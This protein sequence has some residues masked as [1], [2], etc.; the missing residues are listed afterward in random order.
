[1]SKSLQTNVNTKLLAYFGGKPLRSPDLPWPKWPIYSKNL[2][3]EFESILAS[4]SWSI[5]SLYNGNSLKYE[6]FAKEFATYCGTKYCVPTDHGSSAIIA[7]LNA[8]GIGKEDE[9]ILPGLTWVACPISILKTGARP[10]LVD[11]DPH[12]QCI[13]PN[14]FEN[15]ITPQTK[16][17]LA[18]HLYSSMADMDRIR[19]IAKKNNIFVIEDCAQAHGAEWSSKKAGSIGDIGVFSFQHGKPLASG[20]G[21]AVVTSDYNF[22][23]KIQQA[24]T[25]GRI[26]DPNPTIGRVRLKEIGETIGGN[27]A[28]P[29]FQSAILLDSLQKLDSMNKTRAQNAKYLDLHLSDIPGL[30]PIQPYVK[31]NFRSYYHYNIRF[32]RTVYPNL[33]ATLFCNILESELHTWVHTTYPPLDNH[34]LYKSS[35]YNYDTFPLKPHLYNA[36][37]EHE[38]TILFHHSNLLATQDDMDDIIAAFLKIYKICAS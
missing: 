22:F 34:T 7:A 8:L 10:V 3:R 6:E 4:H 37:A 1:M 18:V 15:A 2:I 16:A 36:L 17:V 21:G 35:V 25:H 28:L 19:A 29:E 12:T 27:M 33:D 26:I 23:L 20:E 31:N 5:S 13:D 24:T 14:A 30:L 32:D 11:I 38:R 9:V